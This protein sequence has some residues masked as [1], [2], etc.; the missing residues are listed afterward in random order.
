MVI[1]YCDG[2]P[3]VA[4][5][6]VRRTPPSPACDGEAAGFGACAAAKLRLMSSKEPALGWARCSLGSLLG[7][8]FA[9]LEFLPPIFWWS[10]KKGAL[11]AEFQRVVQSSES[12]QTRGQPKSTAITNRPWRNGPTKHL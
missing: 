11:L 2:E 1:A 6:S 4:T 10:R 3:T 8:F 5:L 12:K 9:A 7:W